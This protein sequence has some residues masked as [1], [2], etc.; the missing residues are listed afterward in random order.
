MD[1]TTPSTTISAHQAKNGFGRLIDLARL[2]PVTVTKH[3]RPVVVV[4]AVE[5]FERL[6]AAAGREMEP[7]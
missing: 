7:R 2:S 5:E 3:E 1:S 4:L 6:R